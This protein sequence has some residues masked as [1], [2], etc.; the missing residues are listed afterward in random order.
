MIAD[1]ATPRIAPQRDPGRWLVLSA[2][3]IAS[4]TILL[5]QAM[6]GLIAPAVQKE[7]GVN[8]TVMNLIAGIATLMTA[9]FILGGITIGDHFG[10]R[11]C[12]IAASSGLLGVSVLSML[13]TGGPMLLVLRA[14]SGI[15]AAVV[16]PIA[17]A[18][19]RVTFDDEERPK[20]IGVYTA[21]LGLVAT[22]GTIVIQVVNQL[23]G[24]RGC[25]GITAVLAAITIFLF[26][27]FVPEYPPMRSKAIDVPGILLWAG[28]LFL[29]VFGINRASGPGGFASP[30]TLVPC[31]IGIVLL[32]CF[33][34]CE[35]RSSSP[36]LPLQLFK[37]SQFSA[38]LA[39]ALIIA[40]AW[41]GAY[42]HL[43]LYLQML[44]QFDPISTA[45][46]LLPLGLSL[47]I[48]CFIAGRLQGRFTVR[49]LM[50]G[51]LLIFAMAMVP[52]ASSI[53]P[54]LAYGWMLVASVGMG[55]GYGFSNT[56]RLNAVVSS[57][58]KEFSGPASA[59]SFAFFQLGG[60]LGITGMGAISA[61]LSSRAYAGLLAAAGLPASQIGETAELLKRLV[62][63]NAN[64]IASHVGIPT[65]R[66]DAL[67]GAY[68]D[69]YATGLAQTMLICSA[70]LVSGAIIAWIGFKP[71]R[72][73]SLD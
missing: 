12:M 55:M 25:F 68:K 67:I 66:L 71:S 13:A 43:S 70:V 51:G 52:L 62:Y 20:A 8:Q 54:E 10:R 24:W 5:D 39:L 14:I 34:W 1:V 40:F 4:R 42:Y 28:G 60:A 18:T 50:V 72:N 3:V 36:A 49:T 27:R 48:F 37:S 30:E 11:R 58:P 57:A 31:A 45:L 69:A 26:L 32:A 9:S 17:P 33:A 56:P 44:E 65:Y 2:C 21:T 63:G 61:V 38:G 16:S 6:I 23:A 59:S 46:R 35:S 47:F 73:K 15:F 22:L 64:A 29:L 41:F 7:F 19:I 53:K